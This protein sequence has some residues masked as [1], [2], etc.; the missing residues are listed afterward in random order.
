MRVRP[1]QSFKRTFGPQSASCVHYFLTAALRPLNSGVSCPQSLQVSNTSNPR[2]SFYLCLLASTV[3]F[4]ASGTAIF[5]FQNVALAIGILAV[6]LPVAFALAL[7]AYL[8]HAK[9]HGSGGSLRYF[10][11]VPGILSAQ[12]A[13]G[14]LAAALLAVF[15]PAIR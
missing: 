1:N 15:G 13:G 2:S 4:L 10:V 8:R 11:I 7:L 14:V 5:Q 6:A 12:V 9:A 3:A